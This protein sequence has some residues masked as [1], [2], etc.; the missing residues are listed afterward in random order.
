MEIGVLQYRQRVIRKIA[1]SPEKTSVVLDM[2]C[3][4]GGD[5]G[6]ISGQAKFLV[7]IDAEINPEWAKR[8][9]GN[10][11][12]LVADARA[13]PFKENKFNIIFE[14]DMLHHVE[15]RLPEVF[16]EI[17]RV[18]RKDSRI[19]LVE[20]NRYNPIF[21]IHMTLMLGHEHLTYRQFRQLI[22]AH[23]REAHFISFEARVFPIKN[24]GWLNLFHSLEDIV[25]RIPIFKRILCYNA[26]II[27]SH[28]VNPECPYR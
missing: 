18:A 24:T 22:S 8:K 4:D 21:Y 25:E 9:T 28:K 1:L 2:G 3:G 19:F 20:A 12:F 11:Y 16:T 5:M 15:G 27:T 17:K 6:L 7:G 10:I 13:L 26:A 23:F 14:K